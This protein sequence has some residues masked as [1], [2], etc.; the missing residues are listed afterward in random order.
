MHY[1]LAR[2]PH[3]AR[4]LIDALI[5][6]GVPSAVMRD[7]RKRLSAFPGRPP[8]AIGRVA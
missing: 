2:L 8:R 7:A 1:R 3:W 5:G 4:T 6:G